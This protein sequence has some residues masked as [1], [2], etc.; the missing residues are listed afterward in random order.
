MRGT[1]CHF[2]DEE[3]NKFCT[4]GETHHLLK[5]HDPTSE[6]YIGMDCVNCIGSLLEKRLWES[7]NLE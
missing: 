4:D 5:Y 6:H 1:P 3:A 2:H 7:V